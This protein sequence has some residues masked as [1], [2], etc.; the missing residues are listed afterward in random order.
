MLKR[1]IGGLLLLAIVGCV[2]SVAAGSAF[3]YVICF[4]MMVAVVLFGLLV[5][6]VNI[7]W[8]FLPDDFKKA[9]ER[10]KERLSVVIF[11]CGLFFF[12]VGAAVNRRYFLGASG[13]IHLLGNTATFIFAAFL[14]WRLI[15][16]NKIKTIV[17][18]SVVFIL[19][20]A[21]LSFIS[22]TALKPGE[23]V[24]VSSIDNL[25]TL[26]YVDWVPAENI[27]KR[28]VTQYK[29]GLTFDGINIFASELLG[30]IYLMDMQGNILHKWTEK[31]KWVERFEGN[32]R[33]NGLQMCENGDLLLIVKDQML[34]CLDWDSNVKWKKKMRVHHDVR[35][36]ENN[37]IYVIAREDGL[38]FWHKIPVPILSDYIAVLSPDGEI[39]KKVYVYNLVEEYISSGDIAKI[40]YSGI[41]KPINLMR[42][43][44][45]YYK[46][47]MNYIFRNATPFDIMH[48]NGI[49]I[50]DSDIDGFCRKGDWLVSL[51][52]PDFIGVVDVWKEEL[53]WSWG[54]GELSKPHHPTLL[55][56]GNVLVYDNGVDS[57]FSRI[58][59]LDPVT[60][61][62]MWEYKSKPPEKFFSNTRG[63]CQRLPNGNTLIAESNKGRVFEIT[64]EG[65]V[66]WEFYSPERKMETKERAPIYRM[67]RITNPERYTH[68]REFE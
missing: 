57:G 61:K 47:K 23:A 51:R 22:S 54:P 64:S 33:L 1:I 39:K 52:Q 35:V 4:V 17:G 19:F 11:F 12:F 62:T 66:V 9:Y 15:K 20:I 65:K 36:D 13:F 25:K 34:I 10:K 41:L 37:N 55:K 2:A 32:G 24:P 68:L 63:S 42:I 46:S 58:V 26:G 7:I 49:Q 21:L 67:M 50:V 43:F 29:S 6:V 56:N 28:G 40:Y 45:H 44:W 27:E 5:L 59:E 30:Q 53:V 31:T 48:T 60:K 18:G 16:P 8:K 3:A 14:G 38:I